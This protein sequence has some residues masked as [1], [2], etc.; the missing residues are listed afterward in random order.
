MTLTQQRGAS[1]VL[2]GLLTGLP[3]AAPVAQNDGVDPNV[4]VDPALF[5]TLEYR[6]LGF[7]RGGRSTAVTGVASQSLVYYFGGTGG[8]VFK[9]TD[10]GIMW[11][12]VTDGFLGVGSVGASGRLA[13]T[14]SH[15]IVPLARG[16][17]KHAADR[18]TT[19]TARPA[20]QPLG[21]VVPDA[22]VVL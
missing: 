11:D 5:D 7:T 2:T 12:N 20:T 14:A 19:D 8:G 22:L 15:R 4:V 13:L 17:R 18:T 3:V 16:G 6:S 21:H 1:L 10:A 9:T